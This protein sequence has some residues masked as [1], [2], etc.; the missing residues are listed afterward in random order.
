MPPLKRLK[1][2][3]AGKPAAYSPPA[4]RPSIAI[5]NW[6]AIAMGLIL[7]DFFRLAIAPA[8]AAP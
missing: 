5:P 1:L 7:V 4:R 3:K 6:M 8:S 2:T